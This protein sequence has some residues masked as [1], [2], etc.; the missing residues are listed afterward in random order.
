MSDQLRM[1]DEMPLADTGAIAEHYASL[2]EWVLYF[3]GRM[4]ENPSFQECTQLQEVALAESASM[5]QADDD[6]SSSERSRII[7]EAVKRA[8]YIKLQ[9]NADALQTVRDRFKEIRII[10]KAN[11]PNAVADIFR[12]GFILLMTA[13]DAAI[14]DLV[15]VALQKKFF[16][17]IA[18]FGNDKLSL[19]DIAETGSFKTLG[20][21]IIE[22]QLGS[23]YLSGLLRLLFDEWKV[24][25]VNTTDGQ[26]FAHLLELVL[27]RNIHVHNRG[28]VDERYLNEKLNPFNLKLGDAAPITSPYWAHANRLCEACVHRVAR[29]AD[30]A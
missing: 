6:L 27:R 5:Q 8:R 22:K 11:K 24:E 16:D 19:H 15:R 18:S 12:Q 23:K 30:S 4:S 9:Q 20:E 3:I 2:N 29:W 21:Q 17:L 14:F 10:A 7:G 26:K 28:I 25:C 1:M 13:F